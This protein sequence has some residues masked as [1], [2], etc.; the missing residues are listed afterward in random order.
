MRNYG[1]P[2]DLRSLE[3]KQFMT[4]DGSPN[5]LVEHVLSGKITDLAERCRLVS[6]I[7]ELKAEIVKL[8]TEIDGLRAEIA[9]H[10]RYREL[11]RS[12]LAETQWKKDNDRLKDEIMRLR[13]ENEQ[14]K[15]NNAFWKT[16][17]AAAWDK[18][19]ERRLE[20]VSYADLVK[21]F[22]TNANKILDD[23]QEQ[24]SHSERRREKLREAMNQLIKGDE[25]TWERHPQSRGVYSL[26]AQEVQ[27]A[28]AVDTSEDMHCD[29]CFNGTTFSGINHGGP[30]M[31]YAKGTCRVCN[32]SGIRPHQIAADSS[33]E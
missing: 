22:T 13:E 9:S 5:G 14:L 31:E 23:K 32:G 26:Y 33:D 4:W 28:L 16:N 27:H 21:K 6:E 11:V 24:L 19:E 2:R 3:G 30:P 8:R 10:E 15:K 20:S 25:E 17:S 1:V 12:N 18:C 29:R 7:D